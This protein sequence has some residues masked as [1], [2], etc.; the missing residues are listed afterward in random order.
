LSSARRATRRKP[1]NS[2]GLKI[3]RLK[4][5]GMVVTPESKMIF[6]AR[7]FNKSIR[8]ISLTSEISKEPF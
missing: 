8:A 4:Y 5:L 1:P 7:D 3:G 6:S 2:T